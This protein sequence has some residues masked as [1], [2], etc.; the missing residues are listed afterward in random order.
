MCSCQCLLL[1]QH[2]IVSLRVFIFTL[3]KFSA[4]QII[5]TWNYMCFPETQ[6]LQQVYERTF[7]LSISWS[8]LL[9]SEILLIQPQLECNIQEVCSYAWQHDNVDWNVKPICTLV[10]HI[11]QQRFFYQNVHIYVLQ[12]VSSHSFLHANFPHHQHQNFP[13]TVW[14]KGQPLHI[15]HAGVSV[16]CAAAAADT[17]WCTA[18]H[19]CGNSSSPVLCYFQLFIPILLERNMLESQQNLSITLSLESSGYAGK[20]ILLPPFLLQR[21]HYI[22]FQYSSSFLKNRKRL[23]FVFVFFSLWIFS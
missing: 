4:A 12:I 20:E 18:R 14:G 16:H 15:F 3:T 2:K 7:S 6:V 17:F 13:S 9:Y 23:V 10:D 11:S 1:L 21:L 19:P 5:V 22:F 8:I